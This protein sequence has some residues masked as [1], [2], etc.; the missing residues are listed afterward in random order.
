MKVLYFTDS[1]KDDI[2]SLTVLISQCYLN[3]IEIIGVVCD[4]GFLSYPQNI[5]IVQFWLNNILNFTG[6]DVYRGLNRDNYLKQQR[7]FPELFITSYIDLMVTNFNY[8][9]SVIPTYKNLDE[10]ILKLNNEDTNSISV[11]STGNLTTFSYLLLSNPTLK[12]KIK[13]IYSMIGNYD[14]SGNVLPAN[15]LEPNILSNSEYNAYLDPDSF[16]N[17]VRINNMKLNIVPLD[18]TNYAPLTNN[19]I[20]QLQVI[21]TPYYNKCLDVF[22][23]NIYTQFIALLETTLLTKNTK[24]YMWDLVA[25]IL[26]LKKLISQTY[27]S[28]NID[29]SWTGKINTNVIEYNQKCNLYN[30]CNYD[31]LLNAI[32]ESIFIPIPQEP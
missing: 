24:L 19:T 14:L 15:L 17:I 21:G 27:I 11:L 25:T 12:S 20:T 9:P 30:Y 10:L 7:Y 2:Y 16:S 29:I 4:D 22:V 31:Q 13:T 5:S 18:C 3:G 8:D 23:R 28:P 32:I 6:I 1:D 26:F